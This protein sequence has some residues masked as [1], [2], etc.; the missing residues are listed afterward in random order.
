MKKEIAFILFLVL[1]LCSCSRNTDQNTTAGS[2]SSPQPSMYEESSERILAEPYMDVRGLDESITIKSNEYVPE[3]MITYWFNQNTV[4]EGN[5]ELAAE[6]LET[7][8]S[9]GLH[10][11]KLHAQGITGENVTVAIIDQPLLLDH[12]EYAGKIEKYHTI[13]LTEKDRPSS[14]H[15][16]AV[17]SLL[18][19]D[20]IGTAPG[21]KLYYVAIKA[22]DRSAPEMGAQALDWLIGQ[23]EALPETEKIRA[24]SVS[25]DFTNTEYF[26]GHS[27]WDE[28]VK[29]AQ[30]ADILVLDCRREY[31]TCVFWPSF[32]DPNSRDDIT[33]CKIGTPDGDFLD[34]P[35][36]A[37]GT[38]VGYRTTAEVYYENEYSY[39]YDAI[40]GHSWA[41]PYG[42]G[43]LALGWQVNPS[44]TGQELIELMHQTAY[45]NASGDQFIDP[46]AF[47]NSVQEPLITE[48]DWSDYFNGIHGAAVIYD[49]E[50]NR[51]QI[52]GPELAAAR[53]SPCSTFKIISS[54][55]ALEEGVIEPDH[56]VKSWSGEVF[57]NERWNQDIGFD[58]AFRASCV[59]YFREL[60]DEIGRDRI[61]TELNRLQYGNCDI[62]D[63]EGR[64][65]TNNSNPAL[66]GFWIESSL[67]ISPK[68]QTEVMERIFGNRSDYSKE[69]RDQLMD[70]MFL[71]EQ[72][73]KDV[74]IYGKTGMGKAEGIVVDSWFTGFADRADK[75]IYFCVYLGETKDREVSSTKAKEIAVRI[76]N[77]EL[78]IWR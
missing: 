34:C 49:P 44:L 10:V 64:L 38:P 63:W 65:N 68:E 8:K 26:S 1:S 77:E 59:W 46:S 20:T 12:P 43:I 17:T 55:T 42:T 73:E 23:N 45:Q 35:S 6:I 7:G 27:A 60:I 48:M 51:Y 37:L 39:S 31:D 76:M 25:A 70:V 58:D 57:W 74:S 4:F 66:T 30:A 5:E 40:G 36:Q 24:V 9:P 50:E 19:G 2:E 33:R 47:I 28:A 61:E 3:D 54:L 53:R 56:S 14:M 78:T 13:G 21:V 67:K 62:S 71:P 22:W 52:Y 11:S 69:T 72:K 32:F 15:G 29:R 16:P 75:R 18:A 41:I